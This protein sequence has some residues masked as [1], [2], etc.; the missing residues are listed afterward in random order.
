MASAPPTVAACGV[1]RDLIEITS[2]TPFDP[3]LEQYVCR[4]CSYNLRGAHAW[5]KQNDMPRCIRI[6]A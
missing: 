1:C 2:H 6:D 3:D 4:E 5:L